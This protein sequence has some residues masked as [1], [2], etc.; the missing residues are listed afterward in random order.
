MYNPF[1]AEAVPLLLDWYRTHRRAL[2]WRE[3]RDPYRVLVS[4]IMLQQTRAETVK[5][6]FRRFMTALPTV[7]ALAAADEEL[8]LK[9]WEGL[10]YY[11]RVRH[12]QKAAQAVMERY[13][14]V[15]PADFDALLSL[16][17]VGRYTAGA[18]ASIAYDIPVPA[19]DG[20]VLRVM[21]R[22]TGDDTDVL[23]PAAKG[24][25]EAA[26]APHVPT[27]GAGDFTQ[28]LI[29][30][31]ALVCLPGGLPR[32][33]ECPLCLLCTA[34]REGRQAALPVRLSKTRRRVE[35]RTVLVLRRMA[36]DVQ[37][38]GVAYVAIR[39]R[40]TEGLLGGLYEF[41]C[42]EGHVDETEVRAALAARG[43]VAVTVRRLTDAKHLFSHIE[44]RMQGYAVDVADVP[45][46]REISSGS[47]DGWMLVPVG[48][49][50]DKYAIPSAYA[51]YRRACS[52]GE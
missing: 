15:I 4:E 24:R 31:G 19:V 5:P 28:S 16:P 20:N 27:P 9:L 47:A 32:C 46:E 29:E 17:G 40:P 39:K 21:A 30:L 23:S 52:A 36:C 2:P 43:L 13:G 45:S 3:S 44:W 48:E 49:L 33:T 26:L 35:L 50:D 51:V 41:P 18:V 37:G 10:G 7:E 6:Y 42:L 38:H 34:E 22:L 8:L 14:G 25:A 1:P 12:L 11:S